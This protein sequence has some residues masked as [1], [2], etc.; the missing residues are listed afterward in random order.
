MGVQA[1][2]GGHEAAV[3]VGHR[4]LPACMGALHQAR[5]LRVLVAAHVAQQTQHCQ[6]LIHVVGAL[7]NDVLD[8]LPMPC[9]ISLHAGWPF[10]TN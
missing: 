5:K 8:S 4:D 10:K 9:I 6:Q 3:A 7:A 1:L 2:A